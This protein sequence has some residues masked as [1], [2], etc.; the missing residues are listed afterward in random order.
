MKKS[1][2]SQNSMTLPALTLIHTFLPLLRMRRRLFPLLMMRRRLLPLLMVRRRLLPLLMVR[3]RLL[4]LPYGE[5]KT[6]S[7]PY[8]EEKT[9][10]LPY[11]EEKTPPPPDGE[12]KTPSPPDGE[13]KTPPPAH[14]EEKTPPPPNGEEKTPSPT[15]GE[16]KRDKPSTDQV[17]DNEEEKKDKSSTNQAVPALRTPFGV[18]LENGKKGDG[19]DASRH[20]AIHSELQAM[21]QRKRNADSP[22]DQSPMQPGHTH[23]KPPPVA[24][25]RRVP[26]AST[27]SP[28]IAYRKHRL[29]EEPSSFHDPTRTSGLPSL[30]SNF[31]RPRGPQGRHLPSR[32]SK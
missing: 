1:W 7:L 8:G 2:M 21:F 20:L 16:E 12:E 30:T 31:P 24:P 10:P 14:G 18:R 19:G 26:F 25:K 32:F 17:A 29:I 15:D 27:H 22:S 11:G 6:P 23:K 28:P 3:R 9:P 5:E 4:P 13:E